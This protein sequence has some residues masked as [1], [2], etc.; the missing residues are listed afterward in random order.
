M[1]NFST[2][3]VVTLPR[4]TVASYEVTGAEPEQATN[5]PA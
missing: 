3:Q 5:S 2:V 4:M 1:Q